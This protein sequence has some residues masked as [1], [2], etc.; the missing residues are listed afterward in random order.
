MTPRSGRIQS[1]DEIY[2]LLRTAGARK[3]P[4]AAMYEGHPRLFCPHL[5]GRSK[6]GR[7]NAF[8]YQFGGAGVSGLR[9]VSAGVG[10]W[11]CIVVDKLSQVELQS[12]GWHT[13]RDRVGR[14]AL[15]RLN[16]TPTL[17]PAKIHNKD[18]EAIAALTS[19]PGLC[20]VLRSSGGYAARGVRGEPRGRNSGADL[21]A[22][23]PR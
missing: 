6:Q 20:G 16:S 17:S 15:K 5:L 18:S 22:M 21:G 8:C 4:V 2:A 7:R 19:A 11:R 13:E 10:G 9:T 1:V 23:N 3:Q 14:L 12:G